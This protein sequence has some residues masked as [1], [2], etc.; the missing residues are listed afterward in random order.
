M[1]CLSTKMSMPKKFRIKLFTLKSLMKILTEI[2]DI[3]QKKNILFF[4][5]NNK[6]LRL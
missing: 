2:N 3:L 5:C 6:Y 1:V 4:T